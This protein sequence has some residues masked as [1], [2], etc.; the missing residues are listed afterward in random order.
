MKKIF[1]PFTAMAAGLLLLQGSSFAQ[2][3]DNPKMESDKKGDYNEIIIKP[4]GGLDG[5]YTLEIKDGQLFVN[6]KRVEEFNDGKVIILKNKGGDDDDLI[7]FA[8]G[9][10]FR[11]GTNFQK[12]KFM[13]FSS[14]SQAYLG[15]SSERTKDP[16]ATIREVS[17]GSA[18]QKIGL[19]K[20]DVIIGINDKKID[21]PDD[22]QEAIRSHRPEDSVVVTF[23]RAGKEQKLTAVLGRT[24]DWSVRQFHIKGT[25]SMDNFNY[26]YRYNF[27][28]DGPKIGLKAQDTEDGKGAKVLDVDSQSPADKAGIKEGDIITQFDGK[29]VSGADGLADLAQESKTKSLIKVKLNRNGK[30]QDVEIKIPKKLKTADL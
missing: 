28:S 3:P 30:I 13:S 21:D 14:P 22:L 15:V 29:E 7:T 20:A 11:G 27:I 5:K 2:Q 1:V 23:L 24:K 8:P 4:K 26:N 17:E 16:G 6:G 10:P 25:P 9:S 19:M 18:A 12:D